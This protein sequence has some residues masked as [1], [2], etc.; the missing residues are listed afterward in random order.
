MSKSWYFD[1]FKQPETEM[2]G[3]AV[4]KSV[5]KALVQFLRENEIQ[6]GSVLVIGSA[7]GYDVMHFA[8]YGFDAHGVDF[9][10]EAITHSEQNAKK[11]NLNCHFYCENIFD[12]NKV[13]WGKYD[14]VYERAFLCQ[15][16]P[17]Q[18]KKYGRIVARLL[19]DGGAFIGVLRNDPNDPE[20]DS[21]PY[22]LS[23]KTIAEVF[24]NYFWIQSIFLCPKSNNPDS[25]NDAYLCVMKKV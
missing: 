12:L 24:E 25:N 23:V 18:R 10:P 14:Y 9:V 15:I 4:L 7:L 13:H 16:K 21:P 6:P 17:N 11:E 5:S 8:S 3:P 19:K 20:P 2:K 1:Y 22:N